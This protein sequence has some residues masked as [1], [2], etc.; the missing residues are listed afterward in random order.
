MT[1]YETALVTGAGRGIG[2]E[3]VRRFSEMGMQVHAVAR[4][5]DELDTLATETGCIPHAVDITDAQ[6]VESALKDIPVDVLVNNAGAAGPDGPIHETDPAILR[7]ILDVNVE[8]VATLLRV[9]LP[10]M[11]ERDRGHIVNV[12]SIAALH[13]LPGQIAYSASK[14][15]LRA[16]TQNLRIELFGKR[17]RVTEIAPARVE[18]YFHAQQFSGDRDATKNQLYDGYES[19]RPGDI[20]DAIAYCVGAPEHVDVTL[21]EILPTYQ[22]IGGIDFHRGET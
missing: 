17:V 15:A 20:A 19:L 21:M 16:M 14:M 18:T 22:V 10:G 12:T 6:A 9:V 1:L 4:S 11:R 3:T 5:K 13:P 8:A 7:R 2:A